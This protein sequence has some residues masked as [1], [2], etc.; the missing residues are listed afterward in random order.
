[1]EDIY[2]VMIVILI[3]WIGIFGYT[4]YLDKEIKELK[5]K[6]DSFIQSKSDK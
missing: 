2:V 5:Q 4:F 6:L 3:I 1:M